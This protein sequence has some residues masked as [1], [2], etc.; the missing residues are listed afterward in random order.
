LIYKFDGYSLDSDRFELRRGSDLVTVEP[1][2]LDLLHYLIRNRE[3]VVSKNDLI[4]HVWNGR[5]VSDS[6]LSSR[7]TVTRQ[8]VGDNGDDQRLI[9]TVARK[10][11][12]FVGDVAEA[13]HHATGFGQ[14]P[15]TEGNGDFPMQ[16]RLSDKPSIAVLPFTNMSGSAEQEY[17]SDGITDDIITALSRLRWFFVIA[18]NSTFV[19]KGHGVDIR[20]VGRDLGVRYVLGGSV[21]KSKHRVRVTAQLTDTTN[22]NHIWAERYDRE[23]IDVFAVQDEITASVT[24][25]MEPKLLAAEGL[26]AESRSIQDLDAWDL[27]AR[28]MSHFWKLTTGESATAIAI[29]REAVERHPNYGPAHSM[30][31]F[32]L[33]SSIYVGWIPGGAERDF[34]GQLADRATELDDSDPWAYLALGYFDFTGRKT[35]EAVQHFKVALDLNPNFAAAAGSMGFALS[36]DDQSN[37]AITFFDQA[38]RLSPRD[39]FN[40]FFF[41]GRAASYYLSAQYQEAIKWARQA[42]ELR[43]G[44]LGGH[45]ILCASLAQAD[46]AGETIVAMDT[47]RR[48]Q[49]NLSLSWIR[50]SVPYTPGPMEKFI[51]GM[52]KAGLT[53]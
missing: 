40:P 30:L 51:N 8:A 44:Y 20:K 49:P 45:R 32:A 12:R 50:Q 42:V 29:L 48:L 25:A 39:P 28:A 41:V 5:I 15:A 35:A 3:R 2:V 13:T 38:V 33:L 36:L 16:P 18:R 22:G 47:L 17:F 10:G 26:R 52:R 53:E 9:R 7:I 19:Y 24:G 11:L 21:R 43:P 31:A 4:A 34:A 37:E 6:T 1:Q 46:Q 14:K 27:V 23:L